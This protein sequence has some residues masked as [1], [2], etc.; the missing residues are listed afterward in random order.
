MPAGS[1]SSSFM[2]LEKIINMPN[3]PADREDFTPY[4]V[5]PVDVRRMETALNRL[6]GDTTGNKLLPTSLYLQTA[7]AA[8]PG[9]PM[10]CKDTLEDYHD[11]ATLEECR[12]LQESLGAY[13]EEPTDPATQTTRKDDL[14]DDVESCHSPPAESDTAQR[15]QTSDAVA[16]DSENTTPAP[17]A[18]VYYNQTLCSGPQSRLSD[19]SMSSSLEDSPGDQ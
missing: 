19:V 4:Y 5:T 11:A 10:P 1:L 12:C 13:T 3:L 18:D 14:C 6:A 9:S 17:A 7:T 2:E 16:V 15:V 8:R